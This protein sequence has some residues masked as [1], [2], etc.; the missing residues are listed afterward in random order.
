MKPASSLVLQSAARGVVLAALVVMAF[1][2][3]PAAT[4]QVDVS[5]DGSRQLIARTIHEVIAFRHQARSVEIAHELDLED[6][7]LLKVWNELVAGGYI[8]S[9]G[10]LVLFDE[11]LP[12]RKKFKAGEGLRRAKRKQLYNYLAERQSDIENLTGMLF[13]DDAPSQAVMAIAHAYEAGRPSRLAVGPLPGELRLDFLSA[14]REVHAQ[15][16][17]IQ[18]HKNIVF[19]FEKDLGGERNQI[20]VV[21]T[22]PEEVDL[23]Q[24]DAGFLRLNRTNFLFVRNVLREFK[25]WRDSLADGEPWAHALYGDL[26]PDCVFA[27]VLRSNAV[28]E[29][30][31]HAV[32]Q[33]LIERKRINFFSSEQFSSFT[34][35]IRQQVPGT[36][37]TFLE[38]YGQSSGYT[39]FTEIATLEATAMLVTLYEEPRLLHYMASGGLSTQSAEYLLASSYAQGWVIA[40]LIEFKEDSEGIL[41]DRF[42]SRLSKDQIRNAAKTV[43]E[44]R[45]RIDDLDHYVNERIRR[46]I[47]A[48]IDPVKEYA[49]TDLLESGDLVERSQCQGTA[50]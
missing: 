2:E 12:R 20:F 42:L 16:L 45:L 29:L 47:E 19:R 18:L 24:R 35:R 17:R 21:D 43:L 14:L 4:Y 15:S 26:A 44:K 1:S 27:R 30:I 11:G 46:K 22:I 9:I 5:G 10:H 34:E 37:K 31:G 39:A 48:V 49:L 6:E 33:P 28:H 25:F 23:P 3:A 7:E 36:E 41:D 13:G 38:F 40:E 50:P 8:T 32:L